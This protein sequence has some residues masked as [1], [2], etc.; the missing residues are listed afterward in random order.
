MAQPATTSH[1]RIEPPPP[2]ATRPGAAARFEDML[3]DFL[4]YL[5]FEA[6]CAENTLIAYRTDLMQFGAWI[7]THDIDAL[8]VTRA[9]VIAYLEELAATG[10]IAGTTLHRKLSSLR[11]FYVHQRREG[12]IEH[13][14]TADVKAP[15]QTKKLP[16]VLSRAEVSHLINQIQGQDAIALRDRAL[17]ELMYASG[18]RVSEVAGLEVSDVDF[19]EAIVRTRGKGSKERIVP[20]GRAALLAIRIYLRAGRRQLTKDRPQRFLF[21]NFRGGQLTRQGLYKIVRKY[22]ERAGLGDQMSPHTLRHT[23]ATHLLS[24]GCDLR[25]VQEMLGHADVATTQTYTH[26]TTERLKDVYFT[27]HPRA[28]LHELR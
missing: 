8:S 3:L 18:L 15:A 2:T 25:S 19:D 10:E 1:A 24:G 20:V 26:L 22:A 5:E 6:R 12:A 4:S 11:S 21:V 17:L 23:F 7:G 13:D 14:P 9:D 28:V 27:A 16:S